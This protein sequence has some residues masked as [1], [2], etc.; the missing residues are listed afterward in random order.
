VDHLDS[1]QDRPSGC[2]RLEPEYRS[3]PALHDTMILLDAVIEK[4]LR[5]IPI[6]FT[7]RRE[8]S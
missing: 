1:A 2:H 7:S 4:A 3:S 8:R 6:G 5:R